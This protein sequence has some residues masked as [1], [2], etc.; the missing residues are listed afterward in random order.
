MAQVVWTE[1]AKQDLK[2]IIEYIARDSKAYAQSVGLQISERIG[3]LGSFPESGP[4]IP[5][6]R[7]R[8]TR[9]ITIGN[10]RVLYRH[11]EGE[12]QFLAVVHGARYLGPST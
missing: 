10:Y 12:V 7:T 4:V 2:E 1:Q 11:S 5:E 9:Q 8:R 6:D 3:R